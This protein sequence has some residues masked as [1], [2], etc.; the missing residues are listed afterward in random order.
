MDISTISGALSATKTAFD[1][2]G[3]ATQ[4]RDAAKI[5]NAMGV[6]NDR[7]IDVQ[8]AALYL[9]KELA[10]R[11]EE[12]ETTKNDARQIKARVAEL[13]RQRH[14]RSQYS[15]HE[16]SKGV[17]VLTPNETHESPAPTHY[18]CQPCM[19]NVAKK[20]I[21]QRQENVETVDLVCHECKAVY[22]TGERKQYEPF[23]PPS[24]YAPRSKWR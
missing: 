8:N 10:A 22:F 16:L 2:L 17:F 20:V 15:L 23:I 21:L 6:L 9:Q 1:L 5:K 14:Q 13:E 7:I 11:Q 3:L 4:L 18:I 19:D 24:D 12:C